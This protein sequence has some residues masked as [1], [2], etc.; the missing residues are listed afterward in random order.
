MKNLINR[1]DKQF[2]VV[3]IIPK[4]WLVKKEGLN[5]NPTHTVMGVSA[6]SRNQV[7]FQRMNVHTVER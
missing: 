7:E 3:L 1:T 2:S 4:K 6:L 5:F